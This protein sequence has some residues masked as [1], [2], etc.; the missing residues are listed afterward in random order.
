MIFTPISFFQET[1]AGLDPDAEA[2]LTAA[3]ITDNTII[4]AIDGLVKDLKSAN[5]WT[6]MK[7]V[8]PVV[9]GTAATHKFNLK[10][11]QDTDA[12]F[13]LTFGGTWTHNSNGMVCAAGTGF[14][15]VA[16]NWANTHIVPNTH[17]DR[18][19]NHFAIYST[20]TKTQ[21]QGYSGASSGS[22]GY[23]TPAFVLGVRSF[24]VAN[25][26]Q[27]DFVANDSGGVSIDGNS[28]VRGLNLGTRVSNTE[29][30]LYR[31]KVR[32]ATSSVTTGTPPSNAIHLNAIRNSSN[33]TAGDDTQI[34]FCSI[35]DGLTQTD[36]NNLFDLLDTYQGILNRKGI[37]TGA[38]PSTPV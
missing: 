36:V 5:L 38:F 6:K 13:R 18:Y 26:G 34:S 7:A 1:A 14:S 33:R 24:G 11:P 23:V 19:S 20:L 4:T 30:S 37:P 21:S 2:F 16:A 32:V 8:Y 10:D 22:T 9:G 17:L 15:S 25:Q 28:D 31:Q 12:A 3:S 27:M 35:G 29:K